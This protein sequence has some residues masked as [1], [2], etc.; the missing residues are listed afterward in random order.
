MFRSKRLVL[1][2]VERGS[3]MCDK[4]GWHLDWHHHFGYV[5]SFYGDNVLRTNVVLLGIPNEHYY[6]LDRSHRQNALIKN[7]IVEFRVTDDVV[8]GT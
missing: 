2:A 4:V 3:P 5:V 8:A 6:R 7:W 1:V